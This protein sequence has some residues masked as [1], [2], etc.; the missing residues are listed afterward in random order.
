M[1]EDSANEEIDWQNT[2]L[3]IHSNDVESSVILQRHHERSL[4]TTLTLL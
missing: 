3:N 1:E 2:D 4:C